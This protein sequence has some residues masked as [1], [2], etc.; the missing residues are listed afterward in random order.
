M[1]NRK[2]DRASVLYNMMF[3]IFVFVVRSVSVSG[4]GH[5]GEVVPFA[6]IVSNREEG[7]GDVSIARG[8]CRQNHFA[9]MPR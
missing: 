8:W 7:G 3:L 6:F 5:L 2:V 1:P 9:M 4:F